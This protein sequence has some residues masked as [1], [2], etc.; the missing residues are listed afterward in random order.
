MNHILLPE[1][2]ILYIESMDFKNN[3]LD[4]EIKTNNG[5]QDFM[6]L[7][8]HLLNFTFSK[9]SI[10]DD[11]YHDIDVL[12]VEHEYRK[13]SLH[14]MRKSSFH[15]GNFDTWPEMNIVVVHG[16]GKV[17]EI[18]CKDVEVIPLKMVT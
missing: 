2:S 17:I 5:Q 16:S 4:L 18:I 7:F 6:I 9:D 14:D 8:K 13:L 15:V 11:I 3:C 12:E 10:D 1:I